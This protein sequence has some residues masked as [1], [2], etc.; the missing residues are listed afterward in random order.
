MLRKTETSK[1]TVE[2]QAGD[3]I[4]GAIVTLSNIDVSLVVYHG[5]NIVIAAQVYDGLVAIVDG[6]ETFEIQQVR[7]QQSIVRG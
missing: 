7:S 5:S 3:N 4:R 2:M 1:M 6:I